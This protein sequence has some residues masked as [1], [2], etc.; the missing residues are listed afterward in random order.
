MV[1]I[2][3]F[4]LKNENMNLEHLRTMIKA[5]LHPALH[6]R[7]VLRSVHCDGNLVG[8]A[9]IGVCFNRLSTRE[10]KFYDCSV[11]TI[12]KCYVFVEPDLPEEAL[13]KIHDTVLTFI[14]QINE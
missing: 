11:P 3:Q 10:V 8:S 1:C 7:F 12:K 4:P 13:K 14:P 2:N 5:K 6:D 9:R